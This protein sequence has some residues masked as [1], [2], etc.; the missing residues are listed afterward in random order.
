MSFALPK[1][2]FIYQ[3]GDPLNFNLMQGYDCFVFPTDELTATTTLKNK[4]MF[5][6]NPFGN[7]QINNIQKRAAFQNPLE[8]SVKF[9]I[10]AGFDFDY[11]KSIFLGRTKK[12]FFFEYDIKGIPTKVFVNYA[13]CTGG[14]EGG[15]QIFDKTTLKTVDLS[16]VYSNIFDIT[17]YV[18]V[19][20]HT[21][22]NPNVNGWG[23]SLSAGWG[24][25][26]GFG[27]SGC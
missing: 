3:F 6:D 5:T 21:E 15:T 8:F 18:K 2:R 26:T 16:F 10:S 19:I 1:E 23:E 14:L 7:G 12:V 9:A 4:T 13:T 24:E 22:I 17:D 25:D 11:L 27:W 20:D